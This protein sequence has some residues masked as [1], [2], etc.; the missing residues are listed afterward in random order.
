MEW[1]KPD[2]RRVHD[3][4][5]HVFDRLLIVPVSDHL[6]N[7]RA[8]KQ[9]TILKSSNHSW[10]HNFG[11]IQLLLTTTERLLNKRSI[12]YPNASRQNIGTHTLGQYFWF[13]A[14]LFFFFFFFLLLLLNPGLFIFSCHSACCLYLTGL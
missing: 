8:E 7:R 13:S 11:F 14:L 10:L 12:S 4:T 2:W 5:K 3:T 6:V 9:K 1:L